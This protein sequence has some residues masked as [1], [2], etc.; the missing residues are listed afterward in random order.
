MGRGLIY[1]FT[2]P[3]KLWRHLLYGNTQKGLAKVP[4]LDRKAAPGS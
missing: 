2:A 4:G 3:Y 1:A